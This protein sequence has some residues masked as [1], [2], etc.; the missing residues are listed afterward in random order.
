MLEREEHVFKICQM[1][2][3]LFR[4]AWPA[5][6]ARDSCWWGCGTTEG[7]RGRVVCAGGG[8]GKWKGEA[9]AMCR[10]LSTP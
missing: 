6:G 2:G 9:A 4:T 10:A 3:L 1:F 8:G 7:K 5:M